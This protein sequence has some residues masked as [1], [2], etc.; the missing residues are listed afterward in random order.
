MQ[1]LNQPRTLF[2]GRWILSATCAVFMAALSACGGGSSMSNSMSSPSAPAAP[3]A[4]PP[5]ATA[6]S[7]STSTCGMAMMTLT[8][9]AGD[10]LSYKVN[11]VSLQLKKSD[12]TLVETLPAT[13]AVDFVQLIDLT[14]IL[15]A[16]QIPNGE[17]VAAQ[18]TVDFTNATIMVDDG[19]GTGVAVMPVDSAGAALG[20]LQLAVQLDNKNDLK[21]SSATAS[22]IAF[23][24]NLLASNVVNLT[25][26][27]DTVSPT[28]VASVVPVD[29]KLLRV[30]GGVSAVD[31][32]NSDFTVNVD[33]FHDHDG[34]KLSPLVVHTTDTTT[35][36][37]NGQPF[38]GAAG[39][40]Q[41][42]TLPGGTTAV[43][44][45]SLRASDQ[46][47]MASSVLAGSS[48]EG[49]GFDHIVGNVIAR[50]G[51]AL[52]IHGARM[53]SR[54]G[55]DD[56]IAGNSTINIAA[57]T[58]VTAEAQSST[59]P[60]HTIAEIS[61]GSL[62]DAFGNAS[63][64]S[65]GK[66]TLDATSGRIR[67]DLTRVQGILDGSAGGNITLNLRSIDRQPVSLFNFAGTGSAGGA[68]TNPTKYLVSTGALDL[69]QFSTG[70]ALLGA[71]FVSPFGT[72]PPDFNAVTVASVVMGGN[73][74]NNCNGNSG[75]P[76]SNNCMCNGDGDGNS[77]CMCNGN[78]GGS[79]SN[80]CMCNGDGNGDGNS[81]CMCNGN[82]GG[83]GSNNCMCNGDGNGDGN[84][85]CMCSTNGGNDNCGDG[86]ASA[87]LDIDWSSPGTAQPFK[88]LTPAGLSL[89]VTNSS[90]GNDHEIEMPSNS[91]DIKSLGTNV[92]IM[93]TG[94]AM[95]LFAINRGNG[96]E[97]DSFGSFADFE[98]ALAAE[99]NGSA[100]ALR[101]T[102]EG[103]YDDSSNTFTAQ[104]ITI[105]LSN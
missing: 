32:G 70:Q 45:G 90:I 72:A 4:P 80:N 96:R 100:T 20:Q 9:A 53:D 98:A 83:P 89:D 2:A 24:F 23:D 88:S 40:A 68:D 21:V 60:A 65:S 54:G 44:L 101:L 46:S 74:I 41:L 94:S 5:S 27:T 11:L 8:D 10:F 82:S 15:S 29:N 3:A 26:K 62:I 97:V 38:A 17:Y 75:G 31:A 56:F 35:F 67:L 33:P 104:R 63:K 22:R 61:V 18:V 30:R 36:E 43:A 71:G 93:G 13:T 78:S 49:G 73:D 34:D 7:C 84:N 57:A 77:S 86:A 14:E 39:L 25:A 37:I 92:S 6:S 16:R 87:E 102:A 81:S 91:V 12:G 103:T 85:N 51:N 69:T 95:T 105:L 1:R 79:G 50:N 59:T 76:G 42:A 28:L 55:D 47:F 58:A 66:V 19:T 99:L 52:T 64:D 48:A